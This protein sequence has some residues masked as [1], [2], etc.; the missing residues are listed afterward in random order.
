M[1]PG[2]ISPQDELE[3]ELELLQTHALQAGG[4]APGEEE[5]EVGDHDLGPATL[6]VPSGHHGLSALLETQ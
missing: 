5:R 2:Y 4:A 3:E 1:R 6:G